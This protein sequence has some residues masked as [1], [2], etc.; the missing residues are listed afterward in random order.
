MI[1]ILSLLLRLIG[2]A[3]AIGALFIISNALQ[4]GRS[5]EAR[6]VLAG[7]ALTLVAGVLLALAS[8]LGAIAAV[9]VAVQ[10]AVFHW[11]RTRALGRQAP[12]PT[13]VWIAL[14]VAAMAMLLTRAGGFG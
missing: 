14:A 3:W 13:Q 11:R 8:P 9:A 1:E 6:W 10:Q 5:T 2:V 4:L 12:R 7:G